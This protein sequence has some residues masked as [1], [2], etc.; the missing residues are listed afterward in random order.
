MDTTFY[1]DTF[2]VKKPVDGSIPDTY[3]HWP[4]LTPSVQCSSGR[5][6][7]TGRGLGAAASLAQQPLLTP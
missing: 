2:G 3:A 1:Q 6:Q 7:S 5:M 4:L